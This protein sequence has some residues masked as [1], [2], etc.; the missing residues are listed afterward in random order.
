MFKYFCLNN[1]SKRGLDHFSP[2]YQEAEDINDADAVLV[3]S[4]KMHDMELPDQLLAIARAG[5]GV[6]NIPLDRCAEKGI[7]VFNTPGANANA[8]KEL[9]IAGLLMASRDI[10][11]G[12]AWVK[13]NASDPDI[14]KSVEKAKKQFAGCEI[15]GKKLGIIGL[16][17]IGQMVANAATHL[18]MEVYG[19]DPYISVDAAWN[20]SR[21]IHHIQD[22]TDIYE[23]CDYITIHVPAMD[24]TKG[25]ISREAIGMMKPGVVLLNYARDILVDEEALVEALKA[26]KVKKYMTDF[27]NPTII[28]APNVVITPHLG[29]STEEAEDNCAMMA[30][31]ELRDY[32]EN[33][34]ISH[35]VNYPNMNN[36]KCTDASRITICHKNQA[37]MIRQFARILS[38]S[39]MNITNMSNKSKGEFAYTMIDL[40]TEISQATMT[41]IN[42]VEGVYRARI[43]K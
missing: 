3:R 33:G 38:D 19:Y 36:D 29:A 34:N 25:M 26:G 40:S 35:S 6:N 13:Q 18:G 9:V 42:S 15:S 12:V 4:A 30:V 10:T 22:V 27:A 32:L 43:I 23:K 7:V 11:G 14:A 1:I 2:Y 17:A 31:R 16:G 8:V 24:S 37:D 21:S 41:K 20:L 39:G 5:A 28:S